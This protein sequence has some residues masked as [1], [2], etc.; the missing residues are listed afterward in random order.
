MIKYYE[1]E[2]W[3][4]ECPCGQLNESEE[5]PAYLDNLVC[6]DCGETFT[7]FEES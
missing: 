4:W 2:R 3:G 7:E 1:I 6:D 5:N